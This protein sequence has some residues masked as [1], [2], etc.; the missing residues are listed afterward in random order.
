MDV[1]YVELTHRA[2][3]EYAKL[4]TKLKERVREAINALTQNHAPKD[5]FDVA[6][7]SGFDNEYRI[8][9]Q[10]HRIKYT[11]YHETKKIIIFRIERKKDRTYK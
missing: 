10:T 3:K 7:L 5:T 4:E 8:R 1:F 9:I 2:E 11:V 6:K